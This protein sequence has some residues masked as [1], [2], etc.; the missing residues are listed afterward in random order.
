[1]IRYA[2]SIT[3]RLQIDP[4]KPESIFVPLLIIKYM[5]RPL[6]QIQGTNQITSVS[7]SA[8]YL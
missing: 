4:S 8:E 1:M 2:S 6:S 7:F 3:L 5:E